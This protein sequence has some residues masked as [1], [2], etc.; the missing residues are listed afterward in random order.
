M[1]QLP[2][3]ITKDAISDVVTKDGKIRRNVGLCPLKDTFVDVN[4]D[5]ASSLEPGRDFFHGH[6]A[7]IHPQH[8]H[9]TPVSGNPIRSPFLNAIEKLRRAEESNQNIG[10]H[11]VHCTRL[12]AD[13]VL[14]VST[15]RLDDVVLFHRDDGREARGEIVQ[16]K[17]KN[18]ADEERPE[19]SEFVRKLFDLV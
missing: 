8:G 3:V 19:R 1:A 16:V 2:F 6:N 4:S 9:S 10:R 5:R 15:V 12:R 11:L 7:R 18:Q 13:H 14:G 17:D